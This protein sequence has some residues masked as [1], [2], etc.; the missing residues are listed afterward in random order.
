MVD[1][2]E[3]RATL[4]ISLPAGFI[5]AITAALVVFV[6]GAVLLTSGRGGSPTATHRS[7]AAAL[8]VMPWGVMKNSWA[9]PGASYSLYVDNPTHHNGALSL[10]AKSGSTCQSTSGAADYKNEIIGPPNGSVV[11]DVSMGDV[12]PVK[13]GQNTGPT[14]Q[15]IDKRITSWDPLTA[16]VQFTNGQPNILKPNSPQLVLLPVVEDM[17]GYSTWPS[18]SGTVRVIGFV[19]FVLTQ[20]GYTNG[21][22]TVLGKIVGLC[23]PARTSSTTC[24]RSTTDT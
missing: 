22:K 17:S 15:G 20:P 24:S 18:G 12:L 1:R 14:A 21:G 10:N 9:A 19:Y 6:A 11:C 8:P 7:R 5:R 13:T 16:I 4:G 3:L 2:V 23:V